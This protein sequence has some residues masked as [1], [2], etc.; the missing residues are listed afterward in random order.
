MTSGGDGASPLWRRAAAE[1]LGT[2]LLVAVVVGSG[3]AAERLS[4]DAG[5]R[6]LENSTATALGL[7]A[8][9]VLLAPVS[10]C[11]INPAVSLA[12]AVLS[13]TPVRDLCAY[14]GAQMAGGVGGALLAGAM[15]AVAPRLSSTDRADP[16]TLLAEAV[17]TA[18]LVLLVA[19]LARNRASVPVVAAAVGAYIGAA[20]WF[21][22]STSFA[23]PAVTVARIFTD[24]FTGIAPG[25]AGLF[26]LAQVVGAGIG[27]VLT[28]MLFPSAQ[29]AREDEP[30][31]VAGARGGVSS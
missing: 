9:I 10:G 23:N 8:L 19:G 21:T 16:S 29:R 7:F 15:F 22:S 12:G 5:V 25:S 1:F 3:I 14:I 17:A 24:T 4:T 26:V 28:L 6:L 20:Y 30:I 11:H 2:G 27:T 18:G 31:R 13:R